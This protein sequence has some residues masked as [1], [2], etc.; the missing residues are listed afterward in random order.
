[1]DG[2]TAAYDIEVDGLT[3]RFG[4][5]VAVD[6]ISFKV[7]KGELFGL[8]GPNGAGKTTTIGMLTT[9]LKPTSGRASVGGHDI[10]TGR[11]EV[12]ESIGIV[13]QD[14]S[15]D[16]QLT[17]R[18]N[19]SLH[20]MLYK[21]GREEAREQIAA[22]LKLVDLEG[23]ADL[24]VRYYSGG[25]RRRLEIARGLIHHPTVL[26]LD[27]PTLGLDVQTRRGIWEYIKRLNAE[28]KTT[29]VLT[30]HYIEEADY[31]CDRVAFIDHGRIVALDTPEAL[32][33]GLGGD[34]VSLELDG[35][36]AKL[37]TRIKAKTWA[38]SVSG[39]GSRIDVTVS[40][41][42]KT[43]PLLMELAEKSR[44]RV[45]SVNLRRP[46]LEDVFIKYTGTA[47]REE[48][49]DATWGMRQRVMSRMR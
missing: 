7:R 14:P 40:N 39:H 3:K 48:G 38:K 17:G 36:D 28:K 8:L 30:T 33:S 6:R 31:L 29:L 20:A 43:I 11:R 49:G 19:L 26:F 47:I 2:R 4:E 25:M 27:E 35:A 5:F 1:M 12:R 32:K 16:D 24:L 9:T 37:V 41:G 45:V 46:S 21:V 42:E 10:G 44:V 34:I 22:V 18:E 15:L 23:K 13:F